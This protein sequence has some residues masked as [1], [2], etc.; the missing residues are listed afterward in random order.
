MAPIAL[1]SSDASIIISN[2]PLGSDNFKYDDDIKASLSCWNASSII[3]SQIIDSVY[4]AFCNAF[5][6]DTAISENS[7]MNFL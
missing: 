1:V 5:V 7:L 6:N 4:E 2:S 3:E